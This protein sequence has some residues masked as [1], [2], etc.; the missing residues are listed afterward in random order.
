MKTFR[1]QYSTTERGDRTTNQ[2]EKEK[3]PIIVAFGGG[4]N[5]TA[6]LLAMHLKG[7]TPDAIVFC[8]TGNESPETYQF[9][10]YFSQYLNSVGFPPI[11]VL[12]H[13]MKG[14]RPR[15]RKKV[16]VRIP[17]C[18]LKP[19]VA[20]QSQLLYWMLGVHVWRQTY[21]YESLGEEC[22]VTASVPSK[23]Y[24]YG[25]C[26]A[27]WKVQVQQSWVKRHYLSKGVKVQTFIGIHAGEQGRL[28]YRDGTP[29][30]SET[31]LGWDCYPL[32]EWGLTQANC[33]S[34]NRQYLDQ[35]PPRSAC[36]FCPNAS[37]SEIKQLKERD[38]E[39]FELG[40]AMEAI[41]KAHGSGKGLARSFDWADIES[42]GET[43]QLE[44]D[45]AVASRQCSCLD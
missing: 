38:P 5:S 30:P 20:Q 22:L 13:R 31:E 15:P 2:T 10:E 35:V 4:T 25:R 1:V 44:I 29:K 39:R 42:M 16:A 3:A 26:S 24:G 40:L 17:Q 34:L 12:R 14:N 37:V 27:K 23:A 36:W 7:I 8:D 28:L 9:L 32:V 41:A 19:S 33:E 18:L 11:T 21:K 6:M 43:R 45:I